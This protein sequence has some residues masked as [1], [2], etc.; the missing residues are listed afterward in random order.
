MQSLV[1]M[2]LFKVVKNCMEFLEIVTR[3]VNFSSVPL[4]K[5]VVYI[6]HSGLLPNL[7][8]IFCCLELEDLALTNSKLEHP[9]ASAANY[10]ESLTNAALD[11]YPTFVALEELTIGGVEAKY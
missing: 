8:V 3:K 5:D 2:K 6:L 1:R 10:A 7:I 4:E 9:S 11:L